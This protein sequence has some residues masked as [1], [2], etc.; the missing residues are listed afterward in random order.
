MKN[1]DSW[2][3]GFLATALPDHPKITVGEV[4][5]MEGGPTKVG[6]AA[7]HGVAMALGSHSC[8][9]HSRNSPCDLHEPGEV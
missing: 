5:V 1:Y 6:L 3:G 2:H 9:S 8:G 4:K 7:V